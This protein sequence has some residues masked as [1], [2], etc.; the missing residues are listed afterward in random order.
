MFGFGSKYDKLEAL[1]FDL[2]NA[3]VEL[4][5]DID[6]MQNNLITIERILDSKLDAIEPEISGKGLN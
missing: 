6:Q 1:V 5:A 4:K 2:D 3:V